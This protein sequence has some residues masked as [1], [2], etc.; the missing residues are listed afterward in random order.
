MISRAVLACLIV[1]LNLSKV[2][3]AYS[4][5]SKSKFLSARI[6]DTYRLDNIDVLIARKERQIAQQNTLRFRTTSLPDT[7][8]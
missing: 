4:D 7:V 5:K 6:L 1:L 2:I 3:F 8:Q